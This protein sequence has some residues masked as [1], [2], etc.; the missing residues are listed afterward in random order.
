MKAIYLPLAIFTDKLVGM[1]ANIV[2][3]DPHRCIVQGPTDLYGEN[4]ES[5]DIRAGMAILIAAL[6]AEGESVLSDVYVIDRGYQKIESR[7][8]DI[9]AEI[10]RIE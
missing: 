6:V 1:G 8:K 10:E 2:L 3:C 9:G 5:P 4:L 7:L